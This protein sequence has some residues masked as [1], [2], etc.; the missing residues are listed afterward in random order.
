MKDHYSLHSVFYTDII[1][2]VNMEA[3]LSTN[4]EPIKHFVVD[5]VCERVVTCFKG[6]LV[7]VCAFTYVYAW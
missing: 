4:Q 1:K 6:L 7:C 2:N 5:T 3:R